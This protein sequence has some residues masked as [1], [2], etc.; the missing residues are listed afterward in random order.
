MSD[1][2]VMKTAAG[3]GTTNPGLQGG[4][5]RLKQGEQLVKAMARTSILVF[6]ED[7]VTLN[8]R[9]VWVMEWPPRNNP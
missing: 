1:E 8:V 7:R 2:A 5:R 6:D 9:G 3:S 4:T